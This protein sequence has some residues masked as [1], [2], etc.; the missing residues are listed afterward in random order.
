MDDLD[1]N[2]NPELELEDEQDQESGVWL[3]ISDLM[4]GLLLFF[5]LLFITA[6][7]QLQQKEVKLQ[8]KIEE[9][10][11]TISKLQKKEKELR[12][13]EI[14]LQQKIKQLKKYQDALDKLP[15]V[16]LTKIEEGI[17]GNAI[18]V[19]P[20][21]GDVS[22]DDKI[23]FAEGQSELKPKGK[24]FLREFIPLY[25][26]VIFSD[27]AF[28]KDIARVVIEGHTSSNG[29]KEYNR[30]LSLK[31]ALSVANYIFS[32]ELKFKNKQRLEDKILVSGRGEVDANQN[33]NDPKDRKV[34]FRFQLRRP[35]FQNFPNQ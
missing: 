28:Q 31:R 26:Q 33:R 17:G 15:L 22:L 16:I 21:T 8:Q 7:V 23:L 18:E 13:T 11:L 10:Q 6:Q 9:L 30:S 12:A 3:S 4:S 24:Q 34:T 14:K 2:S 19:D 1:F 25:S 20:K 27:T 35:N 32:D 29:S 5:A